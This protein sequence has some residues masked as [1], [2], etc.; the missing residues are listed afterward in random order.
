MKL[1]DPT[2]R[3]SDVPITCGGHKVLKPSVLLCCLV[4]IMSSIAT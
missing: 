4:S 2:F 3:L 1:P